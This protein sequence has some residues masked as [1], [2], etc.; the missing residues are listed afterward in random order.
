MWDSLLK[1]GRYVPPKPR[2]SQIMKWFRETKLQVGAGPP[3][4]DA[5]ERLMKIY[6]L[7]RNAPTISKEPNIYEQFEDE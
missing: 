1:T 7:Y 2:S 4:H 6:H 5:Q 3:I